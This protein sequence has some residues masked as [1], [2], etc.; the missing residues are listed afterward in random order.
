MTLD[1]YQ[2]ALRR[3]LP[4]TEPRQAYRDEDRAALWVPLALVALIII[5]LGYM[6]LG[7]TSNTTTN[8]RA[9]SGAV[10]KS[11]PSPN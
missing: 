8:V 1:P 9:D 6:L 7:N 5:G 4:P 3:D 10:T 2:D 11:E